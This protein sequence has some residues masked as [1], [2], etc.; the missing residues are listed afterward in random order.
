V[1]IRHVSWAQ[2]YPSRPITIIE[3][4]A[5]GGPLDTIGRIIAERM[6]VSLGQPVIIENVPGASGTFGIGRVARATPDGYT[7]SHGS[8]PTQYSMA[9]SSSFRSMLKMISNRSPQS[10]AARC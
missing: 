3:P 9:L 8:T 1:A 5:A 6:Q 4:F 10:Q 7:I 2:A